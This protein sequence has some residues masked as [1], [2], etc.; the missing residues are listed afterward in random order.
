M[1]RARSVTGLA[2]PA[3]Q[4]TARIEREDFRVNRVRPVLVF[5]RVA[6]RADL[7]IDVVRSGSLCRCGRRR[8]RGQD[9][10]GIGTPFRTGRIVA[11][12]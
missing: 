10:S 1:G 11:I 12:L 2:L 6:S 4:R 9:D 5:Q 3:F 8:G 7:W